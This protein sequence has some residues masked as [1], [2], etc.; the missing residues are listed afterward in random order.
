MAVAQHG[1]ASRMRAQH[2]PGPAAEY[3]GP[4]HSPAAASHEGTVP[5]S[6]TNVN[7]FFHAE[8]SLADRIAPHEFVMQCKAAS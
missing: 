4:C 8:G 2:A 7:L 5:Y 3:H 6:G 1:N